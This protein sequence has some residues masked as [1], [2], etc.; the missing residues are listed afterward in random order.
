MASLAE[1]RDW[2]QTTVLKLFQLV[3]PHRV[4]YDR[5]DEHWFN[6]KLKG[7]LWTSIAKELDPLLSSQKCRERFYYFKKQYATKHQKQVSSGAVSNVNA[8]LSW[9]L[10]E[11]KENRHP[12]GF[13]KTVEEAKSVSPT[14]EHGNNDAESGS[15]STTSIPAINGPQSMDQRMGSTPRQPDRAPDHRKFPDKF[16]NQDMQKTPLLNKFPKPAIPELEC[17]NDENSLGDSQY[18]FEGLQNSYD[19]FKQIHAAYLNKEASM[20]DVVKPY[21]ELQKHVNEL[22]SMGTTTQEEL[23]LLIKTEKVITKLGDC[24][25]FRALMEKLEV[26]S[27]EGITQSNISGAA[28]TA[29]VIGDDAPA[30]DAPAA[31]GVAGVYA[32]AI[33]P[34]RGANYL[35]PRTNTSGARILQDETSAITKN[36]KNVHAQAG[37]NCEE[38]AK[39][40]DA[41]LQPVDE[42]PP[43]DDSRDLRETLKKGKYMEIK[44]EELQKQQKIKEEMEKLSNN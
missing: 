3:K 12:N 18:C 17:F 13:S 34:I 23:D 38:E 42:L 29:G 36:S 28:S 30:A 1:T 43:M 7:R 14:N 8:E 21:V 15:L 25:Q 35:R 39:L 19:N 5:L 4:L 44:L 33:L 16:K 20:G 26:S 2:P 31:T 32:S 22:N 24:S 9:L 40:S 11:E 27:L 41:E 10:D 37:G 6:T